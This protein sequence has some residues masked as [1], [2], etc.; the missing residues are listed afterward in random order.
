MR[1]FSDALDSIPMALAENS[2]FSPIET[3]S[4]VKSRH[5]K[6]KNFRLGVDCLS[7]GTNGIS[8]ALCASE[9]TN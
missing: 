9:R 6:E 7:K 4:Y 5:I 3:L 2:G 1:A 8:S